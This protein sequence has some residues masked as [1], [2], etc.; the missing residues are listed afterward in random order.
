[1]RATKALV[2]V[3]VSHNARQIGTSSYTLTRLIRLW[4]AMFTNFS[5]LPLR[6]SA[7]IGF[8]VAILS[9]LYAIDMAYEKMFHGIA[10]EGWSSLII[11]IS[12]FSG[13][14][15]MSLGLIGEYLGRMFLTQNKT[16]QS[17]VREVFKKL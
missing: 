16:P 17:V 13:V 11:A 12:F 1:L 15:L 6:V 4:L 10:T 14:Q 9:F 5:I 8:G 7:V 3:E 2:S